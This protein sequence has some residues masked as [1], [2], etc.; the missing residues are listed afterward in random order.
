MLWSLNKVFFTVLHNDRFDG[1]CSVV[2]LTVLHEIL[3]VLKVIILHLGTIIFKE[4]HWFSVAVEVNV[5]Y[6]ILLLQIQ[7]WFDLTED[8]IH[9][10]HVSQFLFQEFLVLNGFVTLICCHQ[11]VDFSIVSWHLFVSLLFSKDIL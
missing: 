10:R 9:F 4:L 8:S 5:I 7:L 1:I 2:D 3:H 6:I 11:I